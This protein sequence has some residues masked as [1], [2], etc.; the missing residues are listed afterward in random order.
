MQWLILLFAIVSMLHTLAAMNKLTIAK[1]SG[2]MA[3]Q[4]WMLANVIA[5]A[6]QHSLK[7]HAP[8]FLNTSHH[9]SYWD[10]IPLIEINHHGDPNNLLR[11]FYYYLYQS[12]IPDWF[13]YSINLSQTSVLN[14][15]KLARNPKTYKVYFD[16]TKY[17]DVVAKIKQHKH[18]ILSGFM[19]CSSIENMQKYRSMLLTV[20]KPQKSVLD[21]I[22]NKI[23]EVADNHIL[24]GVHIRRGDYKYYRNGTYYFSFEFYASKMLAL[25]KL[26][27]KPLHFVL[28]SDEPIPSEVFS[29]FRLLHHTQSNAIT[30]LY[31]LAHCKY[32]IAP[33][34]TY[35]KWASYYGGVP[36]AHL[37]NKTELEMDDFKVYYNHY[38]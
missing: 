4:I 35:S 34:S 1:G 3:N 38:Q 25:Q 11:K 19:F 18:T 17:G 7:V 12:G 5:F 33:P 8:F 28:C 15:L 10:N 2:R 30:D 31:M 24:I 6:E 9:F 29:A 32:L 36:L 22:E 23:L 13:T 37:S 16:D 21:Y 27:G 20:F 26:M 14:R